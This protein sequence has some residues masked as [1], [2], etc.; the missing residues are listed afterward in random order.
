[1][2]Y[3]IIPMAR[4]HIE[5]IA[6]LETECF[7]LPWSV[8]SIAS[9]LDNPLSL[10]LVAE[11]DGQ[12]LGYI[13]SQ[14]V[15]DETDMMNLAVAP[16]FRRQG[17][18]QALVMALCDALSQNEVRVLT[19]DVRASNAPAVALYEKLGFLPAGVRPNYYE[20]PRENALI[21]KKKLETV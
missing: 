3:Q 20:K 1:M 15:F 10:W 6:A 11:Q 7:S 9:E 14:T 18:A 4:R 17:I 8:S 21:L 12:V 19:L 16:A 2:E 13:G 5:R